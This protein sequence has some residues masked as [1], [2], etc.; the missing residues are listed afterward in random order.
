MAELDRLK[1][2]LAAPKKTPAAPDASVSASRGS[3]SLKELR[4]PL[5][6]DFVCSTANRPGRKRSSGER[7]EQTSDSSLASSEGTKHSFFIIIRAGAE[8]MV[9]TPLASTHRGL[10]GDTFTFPTKFTL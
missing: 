3:V 2:E 10:S 1:G 9:A 6:A 5:K 7:L 8:N 4:L